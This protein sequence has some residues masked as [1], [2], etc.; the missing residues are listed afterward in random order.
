M[1]HNSSGKKSTAD[2]KVA[3]S[4]L[5]QDVHLVG[6]IVSAGDMHID[7]TIDG[8]VRSYAVTIGEHAV[9]RGEIIAT[10]VTIRGRVK[11]IIRA[12]QVHLCDG[13][14]VEGDIFHAALAIESGAHF[15]GMVK[16]EQNPL[17]N[18][19]G[20]VENSAEN[21]APHESAHESATPRLVS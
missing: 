10:R 21:E 15:D 11:G 3:P 4:L 20:S 9:M 13:C 14:Y 6:K 12:E 1:A 7:S 8:S 18:V 16:R 5:S 2:D 17:A 19:E